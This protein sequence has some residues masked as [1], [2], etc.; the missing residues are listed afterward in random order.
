MRSPAIGQINGVAQV[1]IGGSETGDPSSSIQPSCLPGGL[2]L[3]YAQGSVTTVDG[4]KGGFDGP[5]RASPSMPVTGSAAKD[6]N[7]VIVSYRNGMFTRAHRPGR[8]GAGDAK[9]RAWANGKRVFLIV[10]NSGANVIETVDTIG[11][12]TR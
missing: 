2:S 4:P 11:P 8:G 7:D 6:W 3:G 12:D 5:T 1:V 9:Q 10:F